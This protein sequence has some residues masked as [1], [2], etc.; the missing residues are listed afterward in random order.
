MKPFIQ[1][2][3]TYTKVSPPL[4]DVLLGPSRVFVCVSFCFCV[5]LCRSEGLCTKWISW[6]GGSQ[7]HRGQRENHGTRVWQCCRSVCP[8]L[9]LAPNSDC[10]P[11][12][13][14]GRMR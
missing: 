11:A 2:V 12:Q 9:L 10:E 5:C 3:T 6:E 1:G 8:R 4:D 7:R 14:E 13:F